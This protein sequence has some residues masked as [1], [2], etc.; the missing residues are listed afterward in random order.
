VFKCEDGHRKSDEFN[1]SEKPKKPLA[2]MQARFCEEYIIDL[3]GKQAAIRAGYS[4]DS[5][6]EQASRL[7]T[8]VNVERKIS[9]LKELRSKAAGV[10]AEYV[11]GKLTETI[12]RCSQA[13]QVM[14]WDYQAKEMIPTGEWKFEHNGVLKGLELLG[15]HLKMFTDKIEISDTSGISARLDKALKP[16]KE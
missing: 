3:N 15:R 14:E 6:A 16:K 4:E 12:E 9:E 7:L 13:E 11:L 10:S 2:P 1:M 5:A 8:N